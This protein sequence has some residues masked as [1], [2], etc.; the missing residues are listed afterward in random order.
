[1]AT[2]GYM[3]TRTEAPTRALRAVDV[4]TTDLG[5]AAGTGGNY[6]GTDPSAANHMLRFGGY[7]YYQGRD[8][9]R[10][11]RDDGQTWESVFAPSSVA[12]STAALGG[13]YVVYSNG[14]P[15]LV[16]LFSTS[17]SNVF[18]Y[19]WSSTGSS[20]S[21]TEVSTGLT[22]GGN[23]PAS[24]L[25]YRSRIAF[26]NRAA[27]PRTVVEIDPF[28]GQVFST[29][30]GTFLAANI[31][32]YLLVWNDTLYAV[33]SS[34]TTASVRLATVTGGTT[35]SVLTVSGAN[36]VDND[37]AAWVDPS[38]NNL[39]VVGRQTAAWI[40][41]EITPALGNTDRTATMLTGGTLAGF[42]TTSKIAGVLYDQ[43]ASVG[44]N[45][46]IYLLAAADRTGGAVSLFRYNGVS[47]LMGDGV[48]AAND[49]GGNVYY[50]WVD[51]NIGGERFFTPRPVGLDGTPDIYLTAKI[52]VTTGTRR[53]LRAFYPRS[54][55]L[56]TI[57]GSPATHDLSTTPLTPTPVA[58]RSVTI[59]GVIAGVTQVAQDD[60][61]GVFP[62]STLLPAGGTV[63]YSSGA[64]TGVTASLDASTQ[65]EGLFSGG[66]ANAR[67][68]RRAATVE[69]PAAT[70]ATDLSD[71]SHGT[72]SGG[73][74]NNGVPADGTSFEVTVDMTG[75]SY[76]DRFTL[77]PDIG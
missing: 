46:T 48:G 68:Y 28:T 10:R 34:S 5:T 4:T 76:G 37:F 36:F 1:M 29:S 20:G 75:F 39:I 14:V 27:A 61:A 47:A 74:Q 26:V 55:L 56:T 7:I 60:G 35:T 22:A 11:S 66:A 49:V 54:Q 45:P 16:A 31:L 77:E 12:T 38:T 17:G 24:P 43:E 13:L 69:Y 6:T 62:I 21:W 73:N 25:V 33:M 3:L 40:A 23:G 58:A 32:C 41:F 72:I 50:A 8:Q 53:R 52:P 70:A 59:R 57:G 18:A 67:I 51:K 64:M 63:N 65:V 44:S 19:A 30:L 9:L 15:R 2:T 71:P 42:S